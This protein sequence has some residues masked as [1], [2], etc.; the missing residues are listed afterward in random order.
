[1]VGKMSRK[2]TGAMLIRLL[3]SVMPD[4]NM[5]RWRMKLVPLVKGSCATEAILSMEWK[6]FLSLTAS[7]ANL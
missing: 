1:M 5:G 7:R 3:P 4:R 6:S 2:G